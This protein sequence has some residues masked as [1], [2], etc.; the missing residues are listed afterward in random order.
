[1]DVGDKRNEAA[2]MQ[3]EVKNHLHSVC[4]NEKEA[5]QVEEGISGVD[6]GDE[7]VKPQRKDTET[8]D[9]FLNRGSGNFMNENEEE[10]PLL[11]QPTF[12]SAE[13]HEVESCTSKA[14]EIDSSEERSR[15]KDFE[16]DGSAEGGE[17]Q[18][19][20]PRP[21][22]E[23][24]FRADLRPSWKRLEHHGSSSDSSSD[25]PESLSPDASL[26]DLGPMFDELHPLLDYQGSKTFSVSDSEAEGG[27]PSGIEHEQSSP[28]ISS[29]KGPVAFHDEE[30][31]ASSEDHR[32]DEEDDDE[33]EDDDETPDVGCAWTEDDE[34]NL[35]DLGLSQ[36]KMKQL[37]EKLNA[38]KQGKRE[39]G[40]PS[41]T[42]HDESCPRKASVPE[43]VPE[44]EDGSS[45][46]EHE[47]EDEEDETQEDFGFT[48]TEDDEKNLRDLGLSQ[49]EMK[50]LEEKLNARKQASYA[51]LAVQEE[52]LIDFHM[53]ERASLIDGENLVEIS[54]P[55]Q[56]SSREIP[57]EEHV[58]PAKANADVS[59]GMKNVQYQT[60]TRKRN[61]FDDDDVDAVE[62][63]PKQREHVAVPNEYENSSFLENF[64][65][66]VS[67]EP[68]DYQPGHANLPAF[69][70]D[71]SEDVSSDRIKGNELEIEEVAHAFDE[72]LLPIIPESSHEET[73]PENPPD[74]EEHRPSIHGFDQFKKSLIDDSI[75]S[76][77]EEVESVITQEAANEPVSISEGN[78]E[79]RTAEE[80]I[81][82][83]PV[84]FEHSVTPTFE[85]ADEEILFEQKAEEVQRSTLSQDTEERVQPEDVNK[86]SNLAIETEAESSSKAYEEF[87]GTDILPD[88][89]IPRNANIH[90]EL[91]S[92]DT[93]AVMDTNEEDKQEDVIASATHFTDSCKSHLQQ[94]HSEEENIAESQKESLETFMM[95]EGS[96]REAMVPE[97]EDLPLKE[98]VLDEGTSM[99]PEPEGKV[100]TASTTEDLPCIETVHEE[101]ETLQVGNEERSSVRETASSEPKIESPPQDVSPKDLVQDEG[102]LGIS[103]SATEFPEG[104]SEQEIKPAIEEV[105]SKDSSNEREIAFDFETEKRV[106]EPEAKGKEEMDRG[107]QDVLV[108]ESGK[109]P[110]AAIVPEP[111]MAPGIQDVLAEESGKHPEAAIVPEPEMAPGIQDVLAEESGK[112]PE[113]ATVPESES[114]LVELE[115]KSKEELESA[116]EEVMLKEFNN[117]EEAAIVSETESGLIELV[118]KSKEGMESAIENVLLK[119]LN[120]RQE[121]AATVSESESGFVELEV[122]SREEM[123]SAMEDVILKELDSGKQGESSMS[124]SE[125]G[126]VILEAKSKEEIE[127]ALKNV[128]QTTTMDEEKENTVPERAAAQVISDLSASPNDSSSSSSVISTPEKRDEHNVPEES[129]ETDTEA[130]VMEQ[131]DSKGEA[132]ESPALPALEPPSVMEMPQEVSKTESASTSQDQSQIDKT[133]EPSLSSADVEVRKNPSS[134][135][136]ETQK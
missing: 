45:S 131:R 84:P 121:A 97:R 115:A 71:I 107:I 36:M 1:M 42:R 111:E 21:S 110:E 78:Q 64:S 124:V 85:A 33:D 13:R 29:A 102:K 70:P 38:L 74:F 2:E 4:G 28:K 9:A 79:H 17:E 53:E 109:H 123:E 5:P 23:H 112:H 77:H 98:E 46:G 104:K 14:V 99:V 12:F 41:G 31:D 72:S 10:M 95:P 94:S 91:S 27:E 15:D 51:K 34:K 86:D 50:Q 73:L 93:E 129:G 68:S 25:A 118:A 127:S 106:A 44:D 58:Y 81:D 88:I 16:I 90:E 128:L 59:E 55:D 26:G 134:V 113:A 24:I 89:Q 136:G 75:P 11:G 37:E 82:C 114:D 40:E 52:N 3:G 47:E 61:P 122:K 76:D 32:E 49:M 103:E 119:E 80:I 60:Q 101:T 66:F 100:E 116:I 65:P 69:I 87:C 135:G 117:E 20:S 132:A 83:A 125:S 126:L 130:S 30:H 8:K 39:G 7:T 19:D 6:Y 105:V 57:M 133:E 18:P 63:S 67:Q 54:F 48:W 56:S 43:N 96:S 120:K 62:A 22:L 92:F 35:R 108:D